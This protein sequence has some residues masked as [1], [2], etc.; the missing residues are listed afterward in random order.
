[1]LAEGPTS[2]IFPA[3]VEVPGAS[4]ASNL[5][6]GRGT[7]TE[8]SYSVLVDTNLVQDFGP[9]ALRVDTSIRRMT[10]VA[11]G[12]DE[13]Q[14]LAGTA[15]AYPG[16][17]AVTRAYG[18]LVLSKIEGGEVVDEVAL[19]GFEPK[20]LHARSGGGFVVPLS[21][22]TLT[23][24]GV[25]LLSADLELVGEVAFPEGLRSYT[26]TDEGFIGFRYDGPDL[27]LAEYSEA[28]ATTPVVSPVMET[29]ELAALG[30][31]VLAFEPVDQGVAPDFSGSSSRSAWRKIGRDG[32]IDWTLTA[33]RSATLIWKVVAGDL[34]VATQ[35]GATFM[36]GGETYQ[37]VVPD[38]P[39]LYFVG[40]FD[41]AS[42]A[43]RA[44]RIT[45]L[46]WGNGVA[47]PT[48]ITGDADGVLLSESFAADL[49]IAYVPLSSSAAPV[50]R[51]YLADV[52]A[53]YCLQP[54]VQCAANDSAFAPLG[55]GRFGG[56]WTQ[57]AST[58]YDGQVVASATR[59]AVAGVYVPVP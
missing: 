22:P 42:G 29:T 48:A 41:G 30:D 27:V 43:L 10:P 50:V 20:R 7:P 40:R 51:D 44:Q 23:K 45:A 58:D 2:A 8:H 4:A 52:I 19:S 14:S 56:V 5:V 33:Q 12:V 26:L 17:F 13:A 9:I 16:G 35:I 54:G 6:G 21:P 57:L 28:G 55:G 32:V 37:G 49:M 59:K 25:G 47:Q 36:I 38:G 34:L 15:V 18:E 39:P 11:L 3:V 24:T 46:P 53:G 31:G 1:M